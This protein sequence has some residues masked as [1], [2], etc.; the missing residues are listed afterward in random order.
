MSNDF[1]ITLSRGSPDEIGQVQDTGS[2]L[3]LVARAEGRGLYGSGWRATENEGIKD[4]QR[5][6]KAEV[7]SWLR[8]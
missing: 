3:W 1:I 4:G 6:K 5:C 8:R 7:L 2:E